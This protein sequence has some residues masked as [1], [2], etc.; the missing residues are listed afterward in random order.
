MIKKN[1]FYLHEGEVWK[2]DDSKLR[3][4][5]VSDP[6]QVIKYVSMKPELV[7]R[8]VEIKPSQDTYVKDAPQEK[9]YRVI[10]DVTTVIFL[11][12]DSFRDISA[13]VSAYLQEIE[14]WERMCVIRDIGKFY[15]AQR[16]K[17][18]AEIEDYIKHHNKTAANRKD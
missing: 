4:V 7:D 2:S 18:K 3:F 14:E 10:T 17:R 5:K 13:N 9:L 11:N 1:K 12:E 6:E 16:Q 8:F 15:L